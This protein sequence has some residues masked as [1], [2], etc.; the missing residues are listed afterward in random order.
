MRRYRGRVVRARTLILLAGLA[1]V[2]AAAPAR[3][4][5]TSS[6]DLVLTSIGTFSS[7]IY[8]TSAAGDPSRLFVV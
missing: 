2:G 4:D 5:T 3:A 7:P 6:G 1:L 8:V